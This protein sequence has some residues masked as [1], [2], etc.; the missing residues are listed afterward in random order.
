VPLKNTILFRPGG[1]V[2]CCLGQSHRKDHLPDGSPIDT[3]ANRRNKKT[4]CARRWLVWRS[5][6][7]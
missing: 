5:F 2:G 7:L 4:V 6:H 1:I 3:E